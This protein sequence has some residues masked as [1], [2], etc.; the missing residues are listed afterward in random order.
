VD[1]VLHLGRDGD[2]RRR[3]QEVA[4]LTRGTDGLVTTTP[5]VRFPAGGGMR[6]YDGAAT[7]IEKLRS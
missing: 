5:A 1:A 6:E 4:V 2:G 3:V 7:L